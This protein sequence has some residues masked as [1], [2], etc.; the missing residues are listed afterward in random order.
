M[1]FSFVLAGCGWFNSARADLLASPWLAAALPNAQ[2]Q[3]KG[4]LRLFGF[5]IYEAHLISNQA[6][7]LERWQRQ[8]FA[9]ALNYVRSVSGTQIGNSSADELTRLNIGTEAQRQRWKEQ[10][11]TLFVD[12]KAGD[13]IVGLHQPNAATQFY[14]NDKPLGKIDEPDFGAAF[15]AIWLDPKTKDKKLRAALINAK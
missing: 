6:I 10:M 13:V 7:E 1:I 8:P 11:L 14:L 15:F 2:V 3:G 5:K 12:V 4:Y 9:L